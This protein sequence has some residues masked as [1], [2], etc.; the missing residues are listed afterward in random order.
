MKSRELVK[1]SLEFD[2]PRRIPRQLWTLPWAEE[3]YPD[4]MQKIRMD[5]PDDILFT[6]GFFRR[7]APTT[8]NA[9]EIGTYVDEW[10]CIFENRQRGVIGE[11]KVPFIKTWDDLEKLRLQRRCFR[12]MWIR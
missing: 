4:F 1:R 6:P 10:G 8:G 7:Y 3:H 11:V 12:W 9:Y 2:H 5:F